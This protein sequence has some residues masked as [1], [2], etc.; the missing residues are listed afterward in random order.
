MHYSEYA[1]AINT[2]KPTLRGKNGNKIQPG[3]KLSET[4]VQEIQLLYNCKSKTIPPVEKFS[5]VLPKTCLLNHYHTFKTETVEKCWKE[6]GSDSKC[7]AI[8]F[9]RSTSMCSFYITSS[10][11]NRIDE[12]CT[13]I[14]SEKP[15]SQTFPKTRM[16]EH[17]KHVAKEGVERCWDACIVDSECKAI[18]F[19]HSSLSCYFY[20]NDSP[21]NAFDENYT[22][23]TSKKGFSFK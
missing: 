20:N 15:F 14:T 2:N 10:K 4:D 22:S 18:A 1:F 12:Q 17:F 5:K 19:D 13:S 21:S 6:C 8:T 23:I 3:N 11:I 16:F 7:I 9:H